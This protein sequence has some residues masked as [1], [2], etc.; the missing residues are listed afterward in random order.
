MGID[1][2][3]Q[4]VEPGFEQQTL[5]VFEFHLYAQRVPHLEGNAHHDGRAEPDQRL[6]PELAGDE[7]KEPVRKGVGNPVAAGLSGHDEKQHE[8]LAVHAR[9]GQVAAHPA[10]EAQVDEGRE[11][12]DL[13][14]LD[15]EAEQPG[16]QSQ[17]SVERQRQKLVV[18]E[19]R[20]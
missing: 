5:L 9:L 16:G 12:P 15:I 2:A 3:L 14:L 7:R 19:G 6:Q 13:L 20:S 4:G 17:H 11:G 10:I 8:K 18:V 1:L